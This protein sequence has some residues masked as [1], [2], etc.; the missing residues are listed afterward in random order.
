MSAANSAA[1]TLTMTVSWTWQSRFCVAKT[2]PNCNWKLNV[3]KKKKNQSQGK[4]TPV[5]ETFVRHDLL[6]KLTL[7]IFILHHLETDKKKKKLDICCVTIFTKTLRISK[8]TNNKIALKSI[9]LSWTWKMN[10]PS[11]K[12]IQK[13][14]YTELEKVARVLLQR[15]G[16]FTALYIQC[17]S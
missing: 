6:L 14:I 16:I 10:S 4:I 5:P 8:G 12:T 11:A 17:T 3:E 2:P 1:C 9:P 15:T 7:F 13:V